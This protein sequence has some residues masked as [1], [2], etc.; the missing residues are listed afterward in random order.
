MPHPSGNEPSDLT[1][2]PAQEIA[3]FLR[4]IAG[5][6]MPDGKIFI[7]SWDKSACAE[8]IHIILDSD[9]P[10]LE[11]QVGRV[12]GGPESSIIVLQGLG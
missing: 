7:R 12:N 1:Q 2:V 8:V 5:F 10:V 3:E 4:R 11:E 6:L 9:L